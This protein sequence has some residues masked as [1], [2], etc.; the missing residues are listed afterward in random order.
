MN[1]AK[2]SA[3]YQYNEHENNI[4]ITYQTEK[5]LQYIYLTL[6]EAKEFQKQ[7]NKNIDRLESFNK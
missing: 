7:L 6:E 5:S 3:D 2:I 1:Y 4:T